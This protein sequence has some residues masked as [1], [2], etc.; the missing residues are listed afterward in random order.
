MHTC[1]CTYIISPNQ[2]KTTSRGG[3]GETG[4]IRIDGAL[5]IRFNRLHPD[6]WC[7]ADK[8]LIVL[9]RYVIHRKAH[10]SFLKV[11]AKGGR[12]V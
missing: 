11:V 4:S 3:F 12:F 5:R 2:F 10:T 1:A 9:A 8:P 6:M 7:S